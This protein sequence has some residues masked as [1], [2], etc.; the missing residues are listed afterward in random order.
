[1]EW[2]KKELEI[3]KN[4]QDQIKLFA[5]KLRFIHPVTKE[6]M[7]FKYLPDWEMVKEVNLWKIYI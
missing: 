6:E 2:D 1:M 5:Y 3:F 4:L 7:E